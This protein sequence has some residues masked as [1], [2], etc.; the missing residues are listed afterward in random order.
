MIVSP[1]NVSMPTLAPS[2]NPMTEQAARDNKV[3]SKV[4]PASASLESGSEPSLKG[5]EKQMKRPGWDPSEHPGYESLDQP[6]SRGYGYQQDFEQLVLALS[7]DSYMKDVSELGYSMHIRLPRALLEE[8]AQ[9]SNME[10]IRSV[11]RYKY[12]QSTV[13]NPPT[14]MLKIV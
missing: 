8:L 12:A 5:D 9:I 14:E 3:R 6:V 7:A 1:L 2:V 13:P 10:R 11:I 4:R